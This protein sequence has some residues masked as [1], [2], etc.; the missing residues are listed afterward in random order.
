MDPR[1]KHEGGYE[2]YSTGLATPKWRRGM[3]LGWSFE[4]TKKDTAG[5]FSGRRRQVS[6]RGEAALSKRDK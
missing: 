2:N 1:P 5:S 6:G 4:G 3:R